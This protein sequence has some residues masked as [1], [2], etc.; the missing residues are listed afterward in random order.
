MDFVTGLPISTDWKR[1]KYDFILVFV[2]RLTKMVYYKPVK[3]IIDAVGLVEVIIDIVIRHYGF[4][5]SIVTD[6][7]FL[8]FSKFWSL[9]CY[10]FSFKQ[11]L[12]T[13]FY[14]QTDGQTKRQKSTMETYL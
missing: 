12:Y 8:F 6:R 13:T 3:I 5:D 4:S 14:P 1:D 10:F 7:G 9:L 11:R 2:D